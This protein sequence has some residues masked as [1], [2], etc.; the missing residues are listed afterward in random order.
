MTILVDHDG[1]IAHITLANEKQRN[2]LSPED[3]ATLHDE[4]DTI[5]LSS[6]T[7]A[8][9]ITG[10]GTA[11]CSG[12]GLPAKMTD[13]PPA[14]ITRR[15]HR[16]ALKLHQLPQPT[17]AAVNGPAYGAG[18][19]LALGCDIVL[20][21]TAAT[22]CQVFVKRGL[23]L[24]FGNS[25]LLPRFVGLHVAK[26]LAMLADVLDAQA[27]K[28]L[29]I[30]AEVVEPDALAGA[31]QALARRLADGPPIALALTKQLLNSSFDT[32]FADQLDAEASGSGVTTATA[33]AREAFTAFTEKR[34]PVFQGR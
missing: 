32:S 1:D 3:F 12:A 14:I 11:F 21:S 15:I 26:R 19:G 18:M 8:V 31:A 29:G 28:D 25:W 20:A 22:F 23:A 9:V 5:G 27:A 34:G 4:L 7:R 24:D 6:R 10:A 33:D 30:V 13:E 2:A 17:I 16:T